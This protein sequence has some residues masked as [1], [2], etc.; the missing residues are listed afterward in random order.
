MKA[1]MVDLRQLQEFTLVWPKTSSR[2]LP[3]PKQEL[4]SFCSF[5]I[6]WTHTTWLKSST[7]QRGFLATESPTVHS[8]EEWRKNYSRR[9]IRLLREVTGLFLSIFTLFHTGFRYLRKWSTNGR[10]RAS[11]PDL[12]FGLLAFQCRS[13]HW[14]SCSAQSRSLYN[15]LSRWSSSS[16][17]CS[18]TRRERTKRERALKERIH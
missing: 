14:A 13:S 3:T 8:T 15:I 5:Q 1:K 2:L 4:R 18:C 9:S 6:Q 7:R 11:I 12:D 10:R 16:S 17:R